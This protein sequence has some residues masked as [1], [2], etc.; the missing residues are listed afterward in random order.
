MAGKKTQKNKSAFVVCVLR[1]LAL[2]GLT[3]LLA[4]A[5]VYFALLIVF[6]GPST[7]ARELLTRSLKETSA[8]YMIP[9]WF[10]SDAEIERIM[11]PQEQTELAQDTSLANAAA[12]RDAGT[13]THGRNGRQQQ[14]FC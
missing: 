2:T 8:A 13:N 14:P 3:L 12:G 7:T 1:I 4:A 5:L 6:R 9:G 11:Q 10:L